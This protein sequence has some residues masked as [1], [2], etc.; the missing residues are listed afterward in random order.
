[1]NVRTQLSNDLKAA[2][3]GFRVVGYNTQID[4]PTKPTV[5]LWASQMVKGETLKRPM[6]TVTF[7]IWVLVGQENTGAADNALDAALEK[8]LAALQPLGWVDWTTAERGIFA[9]ALHGW[10]VTA[11]AVAFIDTETEEVA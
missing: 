8:V 11:T 5:M 3:S 4:P 10:R 7:D 2:L 9:D 1:M 6:V